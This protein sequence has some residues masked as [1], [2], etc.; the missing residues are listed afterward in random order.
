MNQ[1]SNY[2]CVLLTIDNLIQNTLFNCNGY[3]NY[4]FVNV[5]D[6]ITNVFSFYY[7]DN[8]KN[9][10][11]NWKMDCRIE[12]LTNNIIENVLPYMI[13]LFRKL[14][15]DTFQDNNYRSNYQQF[16][17]LT[18]LDCEQL[19]KNIF[20]IGHHKRFRNYLMNKIV[21]K[22][23]YIPTEDDKFNLKT[24]D[25]LQKKRLKNESET[26]FGEIIKRMFDNISFNDVAELYNSKKI[27]YERI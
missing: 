20:F 6:N 2:T 3:N 22:A 11:R 7:L 5:S 14:Y 4:I 18:E 9:G 21:E 16:S 25:T 27:N 12:N 10:K 19:F 15:K 17:Q 26:D 1:L 24:D 23:T 13:T 8:I